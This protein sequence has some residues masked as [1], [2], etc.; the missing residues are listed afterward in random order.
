MVPTSTLTP[1]SSAL[2]IAWAHLMGAEG[3]QPRAGLSAE[4]LALC[5][6]SPKLSKERGRPCSDMGALPAVLGVLLCSLPAQ[7]PLSAEHGLDGGLKEDLNWAEMPRTADAGRQP[8]GWEEG[9]LLVLFLPS[10]LVFFI[11]F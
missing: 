8:Q 3:W 7:S 1:C 9:M 5:G 6:L 4:S 2:C 10:V 11:F